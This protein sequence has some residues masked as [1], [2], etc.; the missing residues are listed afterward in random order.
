MHTLNVGDFVRV[1]KDGE[2]EYARIDKIEN[3]TI[4]A[5]SQTTWEPSTYPA[6]ELE[7]LPPFL[8]DAELVKK[9]MRMEVPYSAIYGDATPFDNA[10]STENV[11]ITLKDLQQAIQTYL[12]SDMNEAQF[13]D[14]WYWPLWDI[15]FED[16]GL[17]AA[18]TDPKAAFR[19][20]HNFFTEYEAFAGAWADLGALARGHE[21]D[22]NRTLQ[23]IEIFYANQDKPLLERDFPAWV[24][25]SF[26]RSWLRPEAKERADE[27]IRF[28][29]QRFLN[30]LVAQK[31][32]FAL[33]I[34]KKAEEAAKAAAETT[35]QA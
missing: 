16:I 27:T 15:L 25:R 12:Q 26:L 20:P 29:T 9:L 6:E 11:Q 10:R 2:T 23:D 24:K 19:S 35:A 22:L 1:L 34:V 32:A 21:V 18:Q 33:E 28:L 30:E 17:D 14:E 3:G 8:I 5:T 13:A 4:E 31:D 7:Y